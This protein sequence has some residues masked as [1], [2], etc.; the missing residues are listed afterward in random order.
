MY[1][2]EILRG[3]RTIWLGL[4]IIIIGAIIQTCSCT[5]PQIMLGRLIPGLGTG[6]ETSTTPM[7]QAKVCTA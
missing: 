7:Y 2:D 1:I 5:V 4:L 3:K 6:C